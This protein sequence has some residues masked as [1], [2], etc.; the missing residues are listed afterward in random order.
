MLVLVQALA[1]AVQAAAELVGG[2]KGTPL[3]QQ[4][5]AGSG[6]AEQDVPPP[7][8]AAPSMFISWGNST[9]QLATGR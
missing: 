7:P 4:Q 6:A 8:A 2:I 3:G 5:S 9:Q 1:E